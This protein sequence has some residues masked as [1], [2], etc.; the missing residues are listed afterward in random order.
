M[1]NTMP[2]GKTSPRCTAACSTTAAPIDAPP[3]INFCFFSFPVFLLILVCCFKLATFNISAAM[4]SHFACELVSAGDEY[5]CPLALYRTILTFS[6]FKFSKFSKP[7]SSSSSLALPSLP[8]SSHVVVAVPFPAEDASPLS[9]TSQKFHSDSLS[10]FV[11]DDPNPCPQ[12]TCTGASSSPYTFAS[13]A[14][15][16]AMRSSEMSSCKGAQCSSLV[17][18]VVVFSSSCI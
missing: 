18:V 13:S 2:S 5:P 11:M 9:L 3:K 14:T 6:S 1:T 17:F 4:F 7:T 15:P 8:S 10:S 16:S 12:T